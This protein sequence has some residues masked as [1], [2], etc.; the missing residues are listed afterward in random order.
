MNELRVALL[1]IGLMVVAGVYFWGM[2]G[3]GSKRR[4]RIGGRRPPRPGEPTVP[5][6]KAAPPPGQTA[7][8]PVDYTRTLSDLSNLVVESGHAPS[9]PSRI[10][11]ALARVRKVPKSWG[12]FQTWTMKGGLVKRKAGAMA[13]RGASEKSGPEVIILY[14]I[15]P[16]GRDFTGSAIRDAAEDLGMRF[17]E[18][19]VFHYHGVGRLASPTGLYCLVNMLEPGSFDLNTLASAR[20]EGVVL[21]MRLPVPVEG[22]LAFELLLHGA[23]R[24]AEALGG[25]VRDAE[26]RPLTPYELARLRA[27]AAHAGAHA[28]A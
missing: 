12:W 28:G 27:V 24:L 15:A 5:M 6:P 3:R 14:V 20:T 25:E 11:D 4:K 13:G 1:L 7:E 22:R 26:R 23:C 21:I 10:R 17:G 2:R 19:K 18:M 9:R 16:P 8:A